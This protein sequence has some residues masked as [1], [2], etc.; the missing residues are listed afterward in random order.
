ML[1]QLEL[2]FERWLLKLKLEQR[3]QELWLEL[4]EFLVLWP[5][6]FEQQQ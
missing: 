5:I 1:L 6:L 2:E 3:L 4:L